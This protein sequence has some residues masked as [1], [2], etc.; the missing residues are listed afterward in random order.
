MAGV[1]AV[2]VGRKNPI[3][4]KAGAKDHV[5]AL[6]LG[7]HLEAIAEWLEARDARGNYEDMGRSRYLTEEVHWL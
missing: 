6:I 1:H 3:R 5:K 4:R 7:D 2:Q